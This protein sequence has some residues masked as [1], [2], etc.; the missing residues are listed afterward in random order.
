MRHIL[1]VPLH[2]GCLSPLGQREQGGHGGLAGHGGLGG[3]CG[4]GGLG[5]HGGH[6]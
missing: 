5:G 3:H 1:F 4:H 6:G 2:T